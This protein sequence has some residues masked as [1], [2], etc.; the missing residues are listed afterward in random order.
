MD[1]DIAT[2]KIFDLAVELTQDIPFNIFKRLYRIEGIFNTLSLALLQVSS[3]VLNHDS[4][5]LCLETFDI[6]AEVKIGDMV[7]DIHVEVRVALRA[8][9][10][11]LEVFVEFVLLPAEQDHFLS[12]ILRDLLLHYRLQVKRDALSHMVDDDRPSHINC[13]L[14]HLLKLV[15]TLF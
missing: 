7:G 2:Q 3:F 6:D 5:H 12:S 9:H 10:K 4:H 1:Q 14:N 8:D 15:V 13:N 11:Q